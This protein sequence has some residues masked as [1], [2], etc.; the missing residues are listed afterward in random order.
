MK[1]CYIILSAIVLT[2]AIAEIG[3][4]KYCSVQLT[5]SLRPQIYCIDSLTNYGYVSDTTFLVNGITAYRT[6][7]QGFIDADFGQKSP[8]TFRI[9]FAGACGVSG[10]IAAFEYNDFCS[11]LQ[12]LFHKNHM[13]VRILNCGI[14]GAMRNLENLEMIK[15]KVANF[16]PDMILFEYNLPIFTY[17][18][19]R[20]C[21]RERLV[22]YPRQDPKRWETGKQMIDHLSKYEKWLD[23]AYHSYIVRAMVRLY[24]NQNEAQWVEGKPYGWA[25]KDFHKKLHK[26]IEL[27]QEKKVELVYLWDENYK[28]Y[29]MEESISMLQDLKEELNEKG[30]TFFMYQYQKDD[31]VISVA[32]EN[33]IPLISL[34]PTFTENDFF[35][36][37]NHW[38]KNGYDKVAE[39]FYEL[40]MKYEL[41]P[42]SYRKK[43]YE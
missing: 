20:E 22:E 43:A 32:K 21:Y 1:K 7:K 38:N 19:I 11:V 30:I 25:K 37:N 41:I 14:D 16:E 9:A 39:H 42:E 33:R 13:P 34:H 27:Y 23:V 6:N 29:T 35:P 4:R 26:Y 17:G 5:F 3:L 40:I 24:K 8:D 12:Q 2:I 18:L 10:T 28:E 15:Y 36:Q 31:K